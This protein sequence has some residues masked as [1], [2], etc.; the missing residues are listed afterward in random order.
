MTLSSNQAI[1]LTY[2]GFALSALGACIMFMVSYKQIHIAMTDE[3][4]R[5]KLSLGGRAKTNKAF[6]SEEFK[7]IAEALEKELKEDGYRR[8]A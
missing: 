4:D 5:V 8:T 1:P 3:G 7:E 6:F 2:A